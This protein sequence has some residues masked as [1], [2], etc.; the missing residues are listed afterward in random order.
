M[1]PRKSILIGLSIL[2]FISQSVFPYS[3]EI[4]FWRERQKGSSLRYPVQEPQDKVRQ[5]FEIPLPDNG[6]LTPFVY[7]IQDIHLHPEAQANIEKFIE[8]LSQQ[9]DI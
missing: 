5:P 2:I 8:G 3:R 9:C 1:A 6:D 7:H 4:N